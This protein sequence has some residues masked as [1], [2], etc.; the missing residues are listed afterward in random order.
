MSERKGNKRRTLRR[1]RVGQLTT[2]GLL[3]RIAAE[4]LPFYRVVAR[5]RGFASAWSRA[6]VRADLDGMQ[7][8]LGAVAP[9]LSRRGM[10]TNGIGYF[11]SFPAPGSYYSCGI[12]I[13]PGKVQ[14]H[15]NAGIHRLM[16]RALIPFFGTIA[17]GPTY[18][19]ALARAISKNDGR[20]AASLVRCRVKTN[21]LKSI[22]IEDAGLVM[23]FKYPSSKYV[24]S[25]LLFREF[26]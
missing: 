24:Y 1:G 20:A 16:A 7:K 21:A 14:F 23:S 17:C 18:A 2:A 13:P 26:N 12:T 9:S 3:R 10:G 5:S 4:M 6:V 15:F 22:R 19:R 25:L 8:L 11:I